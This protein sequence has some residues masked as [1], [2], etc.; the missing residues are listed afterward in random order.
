MGGADEHAGRRRA[1]SARRGR[2]GARASGS[3]SR[4]SRWA[5]SSPAIRWSASAPSSRSGRPPPPARLAELADREV[6]RRAASSPRCASSRRRRATAWP[7]SSSRTW[8]AAPRC[9]SS[10][11][12][13]RRSRARLAEDQVVLVKGKAEALDEGKAAPARRPRCMPLDQAKLA[14]ARFVT[15]RVPL[16]AWDRAKGER[17]RDIL[18]AHRGECPVTLEM[19]RA[20]SSRSPV[21]PSAY[22]RVRPDADAAQPRSRRCWARAPWCW[23]AR[24]GRCRC[25]MAARTWRSEGHGL[26]RLRGA[27]PRAA[28]AASRSSPRFPGDPAKEREAGAPAPRARRA[29]AA[30]VFARLTPWQKTLVAR[31]PDRPYTL[32]YVEALFTDFTELHGDRRF[33]RRPRARVR[34]RASTR[35]RPVAV[36]GHQKGRDTKQ[37]IYRNFGMPKPEGYRKALRVMQL[38][39]KFGRPDHHLRRHAGRLSRAST[40]RSAARPRRSPSTC[41]RWRALHG[42]DRRQRHR[43]GRQRRRARHRRGRPRQHAR[44]LGLLGHHARGLRLDPLARRRP[45]R[46]GG[47]RHEDHGRRPHAVRPRSTRSSR[48]RRAARTSTARRSSARSTACSTPSSRSCR[49]LPPADADRGP[50]REVPAHGPPGP[51]VRRGRFFLIRWAAAPGHR[52][53]GSRIDR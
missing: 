39:E 21:A 19:V 42:A 29:S 24:A 17:L 28:E 18:G 13:T 10:R 15:I 9:S 4:R 23:R 41:A 7:R 14:E 27:A 6:T 48:S 35:T 53:P 49:A 34:L 51:R 2:P 26:N 50:L 31:H 44:A 46:A 8:R 37:K 32:D 38:A 16:A 36:I 25:V 22:F 12:P 33:A 47:D 11:R 5:S 45:G 3:P 43:R 20:G 1:A 40:P 30:T 52:G